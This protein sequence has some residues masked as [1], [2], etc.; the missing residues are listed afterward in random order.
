MAEKKNIFKDKNS[1]PSLLLSFFGAHAG[2]VMIAIF[3]CIGL[4]SFMTNPGGLIGMQ[5][6]MFLAYSFPLYN[7]MWSLGNRDLNKFHFGHIERDRLRG[8][9]LGVLGVIP[10]FAVSLVFAFS[11]FTNLFDFTGV[12]RILNAH[13][14]P[15]LNLVNL[16]LKGIF[17]WW[18]V[19][20]FTLIPSILPIAASAIGYVLGN[21]DFSPLQ[22]LVYKSKEKK[23]QDK[24]KTTNNKYPYQK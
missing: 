24:A 1:T 6:L 18:Q 12:Y 7:T 20:L 8:L 19:I 14:W 10:I 4:A 16:D 23:A 2:G 17:T 21:Y 9:K 22:K 15:L 13:V 3:A 11:K 5:L